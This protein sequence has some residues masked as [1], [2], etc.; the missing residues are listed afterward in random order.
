VPEYDPHIDYYEVLQVHP[1]ASSAV[2]KAAY[3]VILRELG[4]HPDLGGREDFA[5][6]LNQAYRVLSDPELRAEYDGARLLTAPRGEEL[7]TVVWVHAERHRIE[8]TFEEAKGETGL[9]HYEVRGWDGWHHHMTLSLLALWFLLCERA[10]L[11]G[12][13]AG[14]DGAAGEAGVLR[15]AS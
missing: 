15:A 7:A 14:G 5:A 12:K 10:R 1:R 4:A 11:G 9:A 2:V 13:I 6:L 3:R 8:Q